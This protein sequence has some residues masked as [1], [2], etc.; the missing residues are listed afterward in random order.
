MHKPLLQ[1]CGIKTNLKR[2]AN[3][4][5]RT[6]E[7]NYSEEVR[8]PLLKNYGIKANLKRCTRLT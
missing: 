3:P 4:S 1:N 6:V 2:C 8:K 7:L 5:C